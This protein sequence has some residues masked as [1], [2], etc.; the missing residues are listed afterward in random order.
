VVVAGRCEGQVEVVSLTLA[1]ICENDHDGRPLV[2]TTGSFSRDACGNLAVTLC[3][4]ASPAT[5]PEVPV[6]RVCA[7]AET[8][9]S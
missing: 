1:R 2:A 3:A 8:G 9:W 4:G 7:E 5:P 6:L